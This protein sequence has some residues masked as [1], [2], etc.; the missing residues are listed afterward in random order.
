MQMLEREIPRVAESQILLKDGF[1]QDQR[2]GTVIGSRTADGTQR[3]GVDVERV[4][5]VDHGALR[6]ESLYRA[7]WGR[8]G[9]SYGPFKRENGL[10]VSVYLLN[11]H[12]TSQIE[13][14][15]GSI[16][17]RLY[18][19]ALGTTGSGESKLIVFKR[20]WRWIQRGEHT[21]R[22]FRR[23]RWW[24]RLKALT[25]DLTVPSIEDENLAVGWFSAPVPGESIPEGNAFVM[26]ALGPENGELWAKVG[27]AP[28][29]AVRGVQNVPI[30]YVVI[31]RERGA[32]YYAAS[33][34]N[35]YGF[36]AHPDMRPVAIDPY[37]DDGDVYA[38]VNQ[39]VLGQIGFRA[40][41]RV[42]GISVA[43]LPEYSVWY[44]TAHAADTLVGEAS[45]PDSAAEAGGA[46][47]AV[48]GTFQR[49]E[50]GAVG[51]EAENAALLRPETRSGLIHALLERDQ[52]GAGEAG[53]IWRAASEHDYWLLKVGAQ[54]SS[55]C[56]VEAGMPHT[57]ATSSHPATEAGTPLSLQILDDG[58][59]IAAY[60]NG[61]LLFDRR[62][63]DTRLAE[64]TGVGLWSSSAGARFRHLEAHPR[65]VPIPSTL[66]HG[67]P[68]FRQGQQV[69]VTEAFDGEPRPLEGK[70]ST[71][72]DRTWERSLGIGNVDIL[73]NGSAR[74]RATAQAPN[75]GRT[76][77]TV[78]WDEKRFADLQLHMTP[79]G[80]GPDQ[81]EKCRG[82][83]I[84]WQDEDNY[85]VIS[86]YFGDDHPAI[87]TALFTHLGGFEEL[88]DAVWTNCARH[89]GWGVPFSL[90]VQFDGVRFLASINDES[91]LF[92][93]LTDVYP[94]VAPLTINRV[95]LLMNWEWG[96]DTGTTFTR[97]VARA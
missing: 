32:A 65:S 66:D 14:F 34:P 64:A 21:R 76:A 42:Y 26:H 68:W 1:E 37:Q 6:I 56:I 43:E 79:A 55:L 45:L 70:P 47:H 84:F 60:L 74:V 35:T 80:N 96:D 58:K 73:G 23:V 4:M 31:L 39:C 86:H 10:A 44:G 19:W 63:E 38:G 36:A 77:F 29:P 75:P 28:L 61:V 82:G 30:C 59:L 78:V 51:G 18:R 2:R 50:Q 62:F 71:A 95:G 12:N 20:M 17:G 57:L 67:A 8:A 49:T 92:R 16:K 81:G 41:T 88:Y 69:V 54:E 72:G 3:Q 90:R 87:S 33:L 40:E 22:I 15:P 94:G 89:I 11:G 83:V 25:R 48:T 13:I 7:G 52:S 53:L 24:L 5:S 85:I 97:F 46:W 9:L 91:V 93:A 27:N